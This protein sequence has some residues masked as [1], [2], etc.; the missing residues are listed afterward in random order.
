MVVDHKQRLLV[1]GYGEP[2]GSCDVPS[3]K[4]AHRIL[5]VSVDSI[6]TVYIKLKLLPVRTVVRGREINPAFSV[7]TE[8]VQTVK[9]LS[10]KPVDNDGSL[11]R[12]RV[13]PRDSS[14]A[15]TATFIA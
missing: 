10:M 7:N 3:V 2:I 6:N 14:T 13:N 12:N 5:P 4:N 11:F 8:I 15:E 1:V 9:P